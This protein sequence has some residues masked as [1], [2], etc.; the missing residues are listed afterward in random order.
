VR[1]R[2]TDDL[3]A[4]IANALVIVES[5]RTDDLAIVG[6]NPDGTY[7][8]T[9]LSGGRYDMCAVRAPSSGTSDFGF[10]GFSPLCDTPPVSVPAGQFI[11]VD[12][13]IP[14]GGS[15][16]ASVRDERGRAIGAVDVAAL[17][18]CD[19][20]GD[21]YCTR[22]ALFGRHRWVTVAASEMTDAD[23]TAALTGLEPGTYAICY[24]AYYG[25]TASGQSLTGYADSC[26]GTGFDVDVADHR[27]THVDGELGTG[28]AVTG[29]VTDSTGH[30]LSGVRVTVSNA[31]TSDYF[32]PSEYDFG[33]GPGG[34]RPTR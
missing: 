14:T 5:P 31:G 18:Q 28:G 22:I 26:H 3:G 15:V 33:F 24:F 10:F 29:V 17:R 27:S 30:P 1:G 16:D 6:T 8:A 23:G 13:Q 2:V 21:D 11:D 34:P 25:T 20:H 12:L 4:P 19:P 32:D 7:T 9:G